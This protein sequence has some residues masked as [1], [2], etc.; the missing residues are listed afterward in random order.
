[1]INNDDQ[2]VSLVTCSATG[3]RLVVSAV[4]IDH[5]DQDVLGVYR[6]QYNR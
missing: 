2:I 4:K 6:E 5:I 1:M 3:Y